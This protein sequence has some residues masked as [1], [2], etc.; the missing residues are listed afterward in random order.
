M[1][2]ATIPPL[3]TPVPPQHVPGTQIQDPLPGGP[4]GGPGGR[5]APIAIELDAET[6]K[7]FLD[8]TA[9]WLGNL[10]MIQT[11]HRELAEDTLGKIH[12]T[13]L[14][15]LLGGLAE[16]ARGHEAEVEKLFQLIGKEPSTVRSA[17]GV[18]LAKLRELTADVMAGAGGGAVGG[19]KDMHQLFLSSLNSISAWGAAQELAFAL[20]NREMVEITFPVINEKHAQ[21]RMLQELLMETATL[22]ILYRV[23]V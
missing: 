23:E 20:G 22:A 21:H 7:E 9:Y 8:R 14:R 15:R 10:Q 19:W 3:Q 11:A 5:T 6:W 12:E 16:R 1:N 2:P 17:G 18:L 13:H 4:D